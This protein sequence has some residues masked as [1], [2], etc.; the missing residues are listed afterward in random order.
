MLELCGMVEIPSEGWKPTVLPLK[1]TSHINHF[2][3]DPTIL[4]RNLWYNV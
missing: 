3:K 2:K 1:L 4:R